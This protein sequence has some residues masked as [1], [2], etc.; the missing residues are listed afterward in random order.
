[1]EPN[2]VHEGKDLF[3]STMKSLESQ[4]SSAGA[5]LTIDTHVRVLYAQEI[6]RMSSTLRA[7]AVAGRLTWAEAASEAQETRNLIMGIMRTRST[8]VGRAIAEKLKLQGYTLNQLIAAKTM[9]LHG[10]NAIFSRLSGAKQNAIYASIVASAGKSNRQ[11]TRAMTGIAFAG[12]SLLFLSIALSTYQ[13]ASSSN[14]ASAFRR[15]LAI[16]GASIAG[17][18]GGG[19]LAGLVC[20]PAAPVCVTVGAFAGGALAAFGLSYSW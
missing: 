9:E 2:K 16:N 3:E 11:V 4:I 15:E 20:G 1:M 10:Q 19:A 12:R 8:P 5:H 13:L 18:I 17:G 14:K 7:D 6:K